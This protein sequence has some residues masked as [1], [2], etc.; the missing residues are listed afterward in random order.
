MTQLKEILKVRSSLA[1]GTLIEFYLVTRSGSSTR[2]IFLGGPVFLGSG[3]YFGWACII[4]KH[5]VVVI[6]VVYVV[7]Y[8]V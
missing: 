1:L 2:F 8:I 4:V 3:Q 6:L 5:N 7:A